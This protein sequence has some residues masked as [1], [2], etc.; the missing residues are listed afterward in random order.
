MKGK[1][2]SL[3]TRG[4][5]NT[6]KRRIIFTWLRKQKA[7]VIFLQETHSIAGCE[8]SWKK[9]WG[10]SLF[11]SHGA[12]NA[13]GVAIL[14]RNN[15]D[16]IVEETVIDTNGRFI[17]LKVLLN[18]EQALLVNVYGPNRD[19]ELVAFYHSVLET[20]VKNKFDEIDNIFFGGDF[21]CPLNPVLDKRGGILIPRQSVRTRFT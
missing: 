8:I 11:C 17:I 20:I 18:R 7:D 4:I 16:C 6:R 3:N 1:F 10:A 19:N 13:R 12:N 2:I 5:S 9:Q 21:N 14:F 15:F